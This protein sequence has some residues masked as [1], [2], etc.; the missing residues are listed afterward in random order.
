MTFAEPFNVDFTFVP[1]SILLHTFS[2]LDHKDLL[3]VRCV[4][5]CWKR[6]SEDR[7]LW[8]SLNLSCKRIQE[9]NFLFRLPGNISETVKIVNIMWTYISLAAFNSIKR[10]FKNMEV[11]LMQ[12]CKFSVP[13]Q[14]NFSSKDQQD[15]PTQLKVL[16]ARNVHGRWFDDVGVVSHLPNIESMAFSQT[17][18]C[19]WLSR[20]STTWL[21]KLR[22]LHIQNNP[23]LS[24]A[25]LSRIIRNAPMLESICVQGCMYIRGSFLEEAIDCLSNLKTLDLNGTRLEGRMMSIVDWS[26]CE[27]VS[28]NISFCCK[29]TSA[30]LRYILPKL[31]HLRYLQASFAGWGRAFNDDVVIQVTQENRLRLET[32][33]IQ[34]T[35]GMSA[36]CLNLLCKSSPFLL[37]LRIGTIIKTKDD[38][39][40]LMGN[41]PNL[42][43]L[44]LQLGDASF[45]AAFFFNTLAT[46]CQKIES[47]FIYNM[48]FETCKE[49]D[50]RSSLLSVFTSCKNLRNF[51]TGG[52]PFKQKVAIDTTI[53]NI[54]KSLNLSINCHQPTRIIP[55]PDICFDRNLCHIVSQRGYNAHGLRQSI[56]HT[57][58]CHSF[59]KTGIQKLD[60]YHFSLLRA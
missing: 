33:D 21:P 50:I 24:D 46:K 35:F 30:D 34:S 3:K 6:V 43:S 26:R 16:D 47:L 45:S 59:Y 38:L 31:K 18:P 22:I 56:Q 12:Y 17:M 49:V 48:S 57:V 44:S 1:E 10:K 25:F 2:F 5:K 53:T 39:T 58:N 55:Q 8:R 54:I 13:V 29:V 32:L 36:P 4:C 11:L 41:T 7:Q 51:F 37:Y 42:R 15:L 14:G 27:L 23:S 52:Y 40:T 9:N 19:D 28:L 20:L 60:D